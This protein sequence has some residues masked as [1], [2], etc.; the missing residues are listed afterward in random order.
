MIDSWAWAPLLFLSIDRLFRQASLGWCLIGIF[1]AAMSV[2]AGHPQC[3][4]FTALMAAIY[5]VALWPF[6]SVRLPQIGAFIC[7]A[8]AP[9]FLSAAQLLPGMAVAS[10][11]TRTGNADFFFSSSFSFPPESIMRL[12]ADRFF[13]S[14][15]GH[16]QPWTG[17]SFEHETACFIGITALMLALIGFMQGERRLRWTSTVMILFSGVL[18][19]GHYTP[20]FEVAYR[21]IP[22]IAYF[23]IPAR[24]V[25]YSTLFAALL[26][27]KGADVILKPPNGSAFRRYAPVAFSVL[28]IIACA[29][30]GLACGSTVDLTSLA[31]PI[32]VGILLAILFVFINGRRPWVARTVLLLGVAELSLYVHTNRTL[33]PTD[34]FDDAGLALFA[35]EHLGDFR[36]LDSPGFTST[37][38][39]KHPI[40]NLLG[41]DPIK[42]SRY[43]EFMEAIGYPEDAKDEE[44][45]RKLNRSLARLA[46]GSY[47]IQHGRATPEFIELGE[48]YPRFYFVRDYRVLPKQEVLPALT[49]SAFD[50][51]TT[52]LLEREPVPLPVVNTHASENDELAIV[53][54]STDH[55]TLKIAL[56]EPAILINTDAYSEGWRVV[57]V[58]PGPQ[59]SYEVMPAFYALRAIPLAAGHHVIRLEY[60]PLAF[61]VGVWVSLISWILFLLAVLACLIRYVRQSGKRSESYSV[62]T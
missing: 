39:V 32:C 14:G 25:F 20:V 26:V 29:G 33:L 34:F 57:P 38:Q 28:L 18:S 8:I 45:L 13:G 52:V 56:A 37:R 17:R 4:Y 58:Q 31:L 61:R 24:L 48:P 30:I 53:D 55:F 27:G 46:R 51:R 19:L 6:F 62:C 35:S 47:Y 3:V 9:V 59:P 10:E 42:L 41:S 5:C 11:C 60:S 49:D 1:S 15:F 22:G 23:R 44:V 7:V 36:V 2:L 16:G 12:V 40:P 50:P 43:I 54:S 21:W